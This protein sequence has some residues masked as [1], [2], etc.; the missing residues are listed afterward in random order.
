MDGIQGAVLRVKLRHLETWT[1][2]R[3]THAK[4]YSKRFAAEAIAVPR[5]MP[6]ARHVYHVY[7]LRALERSE[8]QARLQQAGVQTGIH[9][10][11]PVHLQPAYAELGYQA[12]DFPV[13]EQVAKE[14]LSLPMY[15]EL[16]EAQLETVAREVIDGSLCLAS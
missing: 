15:P 16:T 12:G 4:N 1:E 6:Y 3:R 9:Y 5:E 11:I 8:L 2:L 13:A 10:P 14:V 7:S